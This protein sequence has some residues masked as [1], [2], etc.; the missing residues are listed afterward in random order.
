M[1]RSFFEDLDQNRRDFRRIYTAHEIPPHVAR[2]IA[3]SFSAQW[4]QI[5]HPK[6]PLIFAATAGPSI[7]TSRR[8][9]QRR[10][11]AGALWRRRSGSLIFASA[12]RPSGMSRRDSRSRPLR[13]ARV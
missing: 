12:A 9:Y 5:H 3:L 2:D 8:G 6:P 11:A 4:I 13:A 10:R 7:K 1:L